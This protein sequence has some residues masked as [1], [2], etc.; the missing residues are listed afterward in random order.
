M[1]DDLGIRSSS[2]P[3]SATFEVRAKGLKIVNLSIE[4]YGHGAVFVVDGLVASLYVDDA[5]PPHSETYRG[6]GKEAFV[7]R[8]AVHDC[9][10]HSADM[11][12]RHVRI[13]RPLIQARYAAHGE[14][15]LVFDICEIIEINSSG[16]F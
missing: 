6:V 11:R 15:S 7:I 4:N 10:A 5:E 3:V 2:K 12:A 8:P 14:S 13:I 16:I 9:T 1:N